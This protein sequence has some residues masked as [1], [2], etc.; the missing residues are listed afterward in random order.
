MNN[1]QQLPIGVFDSGVGGLSVLKVLQ[2]Q[3]P[4]EDFIYIGDNANNPVGNR[5]DDEITFLA[6]R[7]AEAL[8]KQPV[9][10]MVIACNTFTVVALDEVRE[11]VSVP[12]IGVSQGVKTAISESKSNTIGIM[13][14][15]ATVNSHIHKHVALEVDPEVLVWEQPCPELAGLIEQGHLDDFFVRDVCEEYVEPLLSREIDVVV[16]GCTHFPF[17]KPLLEELTAGRIQFVDPAYETSNLVCRILL[18][19]FSNSFLE[20]ILFDVNILSKCI[21]ATLT[22][23]LNIDTVKQLSS[24][25][26]FVRCQTKVHNCKCSYLL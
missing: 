16:L 22:A 14:T 8:E 11:R 9:K 25:N 26:K 23:H 6:C 4:N 17:V 15:V 12:V 19:K 5:S 2:E 3:F 1:V 20:F 18:Q 13:A 24:N 10:L 7:I 21:S